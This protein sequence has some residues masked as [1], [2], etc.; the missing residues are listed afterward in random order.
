MIDW[1]VLINI[2]QNLSFFLAFALLF[3]AVYVLGK[4]DVFNKQVRLSQICPELSSLEPETKEE[5]QQNEL[6]RKLAEA[7]GA[8]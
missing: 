7:A 3:H 5:K 2:I 1:F 8:S 6:K 4:Y